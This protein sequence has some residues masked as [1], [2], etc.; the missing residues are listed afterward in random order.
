M[1]FYEK[2]AMADPGQD[3]TWDFTKGSCPP[4]RYRPVHGG[5]AGTCRTDSTGAFKTLASI[6]VKGM[7]APFVTAAK[8]A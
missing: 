5:T 1:F 8:V 6:F 7:E 3:S 2:G 4:D